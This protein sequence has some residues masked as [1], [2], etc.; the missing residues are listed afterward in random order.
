M[1]HYPSFSTPLQR[2]AAAADLWMELTGRK[3]AAEFELAKEA[4][5][6]CAEIY[7]HQGIEARA[8]KED[9]P[10]LIKRPVRAGVLAGGGAGAGIAGLAAHYHNSRTARVAAETV[11]KAG[12]VFAHPVAPVA[13]HLSAVPMRHALLGGG[14]VGAGI[15]GAVGTGIALR[16]LLKKPLPQPSGEPKAV[17]GGIVKKGVGPT[18]VL[19]FFT[20]T[21][22]MRRATGAT[23]LALPAGI[24]GYLIERGK[25][26]PGAGGKSS[27]EIKAEHA[28]AEHIDRVAH[29]G[30]NSLPQ[31]L[32]GKF[33]AARLNAAIE[34]REDPERAARI[35]ALPYMGLAGLAGMGLGP[36][37]LR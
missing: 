28:L 6:K 8:A 24:A 23:A 31:N 3:A 14:A 30:K 36:G 12:K 34:A 33:L 7:S 26:A 4:M 11:R 5:E 20:G 19:K 27:H 16:R 2:Q 37:I 9:K 1:S 35:G 29:G 17:P 13:A 21:P 22:G 25:H 15:G 18:D 10:P 32:K